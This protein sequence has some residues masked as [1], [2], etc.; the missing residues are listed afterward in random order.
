MGYTEIF[1]KAGIPLTGG[2]VCFVAGTVILGVLS[3]IAV[4]GAGAWLNSLV[5]I[6]LLSRSKPSPFL[7]IFFTLKV[8]LWGL[9]L[10]PI[11][12]LGVNP[13]FVVP[14]ITIGLIILYYRSKILIEKDDT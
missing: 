9:V 2:N 11:V 14:G 10:F 6:R 1:F 7:W 3:G 5:F 8:A 4:V 12:I 13:C